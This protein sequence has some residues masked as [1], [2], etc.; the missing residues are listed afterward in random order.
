MTV[1]VG[2]TISVGGLLVG[3]EVL[4]VMRC[5]GGDGGSRVVGVESEK[6]GERRESTFS[7]G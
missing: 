5:R 1:M 7:G 6:Y 2:G 4:M 3:A